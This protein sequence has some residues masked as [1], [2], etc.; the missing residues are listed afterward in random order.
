MGF[1]ATL[2]FADFANI[3]DYFG[4]GGNLAGTFN[5]VH[6]YGAALDS[7]TDSGYIRTYVQSASVQPGVQLASDVSDSGGS[8]EQARIIS[9]GDRN[10][11]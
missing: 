11:W 5:S 9:I 6:G 3:G 8:G 7:F 1:A 10:W 4:V 2:Q